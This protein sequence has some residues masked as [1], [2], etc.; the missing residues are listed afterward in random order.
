MPKPQIIAEASVTKLDAR[1]RDAVL[2]AGSHGGV[3]AGYLAARAGVRA[4]ILNDA[5]VGKERAGI[6]S[7]QYLERI[8]MAA[9]TAGHMSARIGEGADMLARGVITHANAIASRLGVR[10][11]QSCAE[12]AER[13]R[14]APV[15][16]AA[17]PP[18]E[19]ARFPIRETPG[20]L[21]IW[22]LDSVSLV[23]PADKTR[24]LVIGSHGGIL[25]GKP[26]TAMKHDAIAAVFNDAGVGIDGAALTRLPPL[27]ARGIAAVTV[28]C[29]SARIGDARSAWETGV[30][31]HVNE[32]AKTLGA[33]P[34]MS[35]QEFVGL[36]IAK[37]RKKNG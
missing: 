3:I 20:E 36:V 15:A 2:V 25:A 32:I 35:T 24:V 19:E 4:V 5:G 26:E 37:H 21:A 27:A 33:R 6:S 34:G 13:L 9:A 31:S 1:H 11:G 10:A 23:E 18:Y 30:L 22:G 14:A 7:L 8:G 28:D 12:A 17:A 29:M 16:T